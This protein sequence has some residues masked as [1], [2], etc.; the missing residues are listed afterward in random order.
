MHVGDLNL[1]FRG[2]IDCT[3]MI[4]NMHLIFQSSIILIIISNK[5]FVQMIKYTK[6]LSK[7]LSGVCSYEKI[8][9]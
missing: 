2:Y 4:L 9:K 1:L 6:F 3:W 8:N 7:F 5:C